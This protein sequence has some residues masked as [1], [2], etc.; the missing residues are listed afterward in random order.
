MEGYTLITALYPFCV[1]ELPDCPLILI[2]Q[3]TLEV[4]RDFFSRTQC[5]QYE[6]PAI[7]LVVDQADYDIDPPVEGSEIDMVVKLEQET[8]ELGARDHY[9][10][11]EEK[12]TITLVNAP[13]AAVTDGLVATVAL[14]PKLSCTEVPTRQYSDWHDTWASG[15]KSRLMLMPGRS[16]S[17]EK[18]GVYYHGQ[19]ELGVS[20]AAWAVKRK[21]T[22]KTMFVK[23]RFA[24]A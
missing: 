3:H 11:D 17:N 16:W 15:V 19:Y 8:T 20:S 23:P 22:N 10:L 5:W 14:I 2:K 21:R 9:E 1:P 13:D 4:M 24:F 18:L 6:L 12:R 7:S